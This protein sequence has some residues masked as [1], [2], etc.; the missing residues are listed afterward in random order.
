MLRPTVNWP[1][2]LGINHPFRCIRLDFYYRKTDAGLLM[3]GA[4]SDER[5]GLS[6][7][8]CCWPSLAQSYSGSTPT[9][10]ATVF[11]CLGFETSLFV[12][13]YNPQDYGGGI[14]PRLHTGKLPTFL[15]FH[16]VPI[17]A[18][19]IENTV[20]SGTFIVPLPI[21]VSQLSGNMSQYIAPRY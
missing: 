1:V 9:G 17:S 19:C 18:D 4:L 10:L 13:S 14:R 6:F 8:N 11:Y 7:T 3:W 16:D 12:V 21:K 5:T 2:F 20:P 15:L